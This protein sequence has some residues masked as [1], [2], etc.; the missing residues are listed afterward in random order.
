MDE[1]EL[2]STLRYVAAFL[3]R[4]KDWHVAHVAALAEN[5]KLGYMEPDEKEITVAA[6]NLEIARADHLRIA[7]RLQVVSAL[8][9]KKIE[10]TAYDRWRNDTKDH[11]SFM[12]PETLAD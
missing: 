3:G 6:G 7:D 10:G 12:E 9:R 2:M 1:A 11:P 5:V 4:K 8:R